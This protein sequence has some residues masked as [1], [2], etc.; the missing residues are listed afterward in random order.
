MFHSLAFQQK[1]LETKVYQ[2]LY[3]L[4][5]ARDSLF[6]GCV[7]IYHVGW[8][9]GLTLHTTEKYHDKKGTLESRSF[10]G[11]LSEF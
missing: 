4:T 8:F 11:C 6:Y 3:G 9:S 7:L 1:A 10:R 5:P 2:P